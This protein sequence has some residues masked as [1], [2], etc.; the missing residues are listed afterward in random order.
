MFDDEF[1]D[2]EPDGIPW[3]VWV[4]LA[5]FGVVALCLMLGCGPGPA[6]QNFPGKVP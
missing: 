1:Y 5:F 2:H 4:M 3:P 6:N